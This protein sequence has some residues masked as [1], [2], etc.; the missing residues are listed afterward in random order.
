MEYLLQSHN[1]TAAI[2]CFFFPILLIIYCCEYIKTAANDKQ[3]IHFFPLVFV[4]GISNAASVDVHG[5]VVGSVVSV[6]CG[7]AVV[8]VVAVGK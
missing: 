7:V 3:Q 6:V 5:F 4:A 1:R 2:N 8:S